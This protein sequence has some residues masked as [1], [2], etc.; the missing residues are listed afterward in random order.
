MLNLERNN[1]DLSVSPYLRQHQANP[2]WWQEWNNEVLSEAVRLNKPLFVSV[3]YSTCHWC[4]VMAAHAF[5]DPETAE[6]L[7]RSFI[8]IKVDRELRPDIDQF[9]MQ[10]AVSLFGRGG[11]PLNAFLTPD[12]QPVYSVLYAT[13]AELQATA[14]QVLD[15]FLQRARWM[16][17]FKAAWQPP[18]EAQEQ[19]LVKRLLAFQD[20]EFGGFGK[21]AKF[22]PHSTLLFLLYHQSVEPDAAVQSICEQTLDFIMLRGLTDHLQGGIF[23]YCVDRAWTIPHFEKMLY[24][25]AMSLW[26]YSLAAKVFKRDDYRR[27]ALRIASCLEDS[28]SVSPE[29]ADFRTP[30]LYDR[31]TMAVFS[32][33]GSQVPAE[34]KSVDALYY[35][36]LDADTDHQEGAT[37]LWTYEGLQLS[38]TAREFARLTEVY[39]IDKAG[40]FEDKIHLIRKNDDPIDE[41]EA[42][43]LD[44]RRHR[45]Q[46]HRDEKILCGLNALTAIALLQA[47]RH[48]EMPVFEKKAAR[49]VR[50][51]LSVFWDGQ[52]LG[53]AMSGGQMQKTS[54]LFDAAAILLASSLLYELHPSWRSVLDAMFKY[55]ESFRRDGIWYESVSD[56]F[57]PVAAS[58][59]D[60]PIPSSVSMAET[61]LIR[62]AF[63][64]G[65]DIFPKAYVQPYQ[66]DFYNIGVMISK[67]LF[68]VITRE[69]I[70]PWREVSPNTIQVIGHPP[71]DCFKGVCS[72]G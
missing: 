9:L 18:A 56:D 15:H 1:L 69:Q 65:R 11:W 20:A 34:S 17:P 16:P 61:S 67:G 55:V 50:Q 52:T 54:F 8:C 68:H 37:Y 71:S 64:T 51:L 38:V 44:I 43:L 42:K 59:Y 53:H 2:V 10:Y 63:Q 48:L 46:P 47:G 35:T 19:Q 72:P 24:D 25:Q 33:T 28:F 26:C 14:A 32:L 13:P 58:W 57:Q 31:E 6:L 62:S 70:K 12:Q 36:A 49:M 5:S 4:H 21:G 60:H 7:N 3:G 27:M 23:R 40:N 45:E 39:A 30:G 29:A 22:P 41:I 66:V